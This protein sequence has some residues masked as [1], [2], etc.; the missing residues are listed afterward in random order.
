MIDTDNKL[1]EGKPNALLTNLDNAKKCSEVM[2]QVTKGS[3][4]LIIYHDHCLDGAVSA[5]QM[6]EFVKLN[7]RKVSLLAAEY[8]TDI[9]QA[10]EDQF[11]HLIFFVDFSADIQLLNE[12]VDQGSEVVVIDHH[13]TFI[14]AFKQ[15]KDNKFTYYLND[16]SQCLSDEDK[17]SGASL[18]RSFIEL[19]WKSKLEAPRYQ[20]LDK[21]INLTRHHDLWIHKG[22][23]DS[24]A[25]ALSFWQTDNRYDKLCY[26]LDNNLINDATVEFMVAKGRERLD[27]L[28]KQ[29]ND[30]I[31]MGQEVIYKNE[32]ALVYQCEY[33]L[34]SIAGSLVNKNYP[35]SISYFVTDKNTY[36]VS[37]R[38]A[39]K[40]EVKASEIASEHGGGG[41]RSAAGFYSDVS[42]R[43][44]F[45]N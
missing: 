16:E 39:D 42:P 22:D 7:G 13:I 32:K 15:S 38:T 21:L 31:E 29:I 26:I 6:K 11:Y 41:H 25:L 33:H 30:R 44:L 12:L 2:R 3:K 18:V 5:Y 4:I 40:S 9:R 10:L 35:I 34:A 37:V 1:A 24:D 17:E 19:V 45:A 36:K 28:I 27:G 8:K 20:C 14:N 23:I 43:S